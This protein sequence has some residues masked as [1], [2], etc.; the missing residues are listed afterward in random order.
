MPSCSLERRVPFSPEQ[1]F[2]LVIDVERYR[3]FMPFEF[4]AH[5]IERGTDSL[6]S[7]QALRIGPMPLK[8][9]TNASFQRPDWIRVVSTSR[10]LKYF[11]IAWTFTRLAEGCSIR[12]QV[13]CTADS[14]LLAA[15]LEPWVE[16]FTH[17]LISAFERRAS[18]IYN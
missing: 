18:E 11:L 12:A 15:L 13:E 17:S 6:L 7:S 1:M 8:F 2:D 3:E 4:D 5:I 16:A 10:P 9:N 14:P